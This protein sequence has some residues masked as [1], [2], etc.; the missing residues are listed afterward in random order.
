MLFLATGNPLGAKTDPSSKSGFSSEPE[1]WQKLLSLL[2][3]VYKQFACRGWEVSFLSVE[4]PV[5]VMVWAQFLDS[6]ALSPAAFVSPCLLIGC[7]W[8]VNTSG[9]SVRISEPQ[10]CP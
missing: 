10:K 2:A 7:I 5:P 1:K 4:G 8:S 3:P 6:R 9:L